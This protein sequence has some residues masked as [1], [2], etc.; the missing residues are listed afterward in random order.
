MVTDL[1][2][3]IPM[4]LLGCPL[5]NKGNF[6]KTNEK[7]DN[8]FTWGDAVLVKKNAP[9]AFHPGE[10]ASICSVIMTLPHLLVQH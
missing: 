5:N 7:E 6:M 8:K 9:Q 3:L 10:F 2:F 1:G 4:E